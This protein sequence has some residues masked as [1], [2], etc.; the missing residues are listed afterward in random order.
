MQIHSVGPDPGKPTFYLVSDIDCEPI[1]SATNG[2]V[3]NNV[4]TLMIQYH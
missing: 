2:R 1:F 3:S 4:L